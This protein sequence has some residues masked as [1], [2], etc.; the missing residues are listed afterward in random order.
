MPQAPSPL[1][2]A[3]AAALALALLLA[4]RS[5]LAA[6]P[7]YGSRVINVCA[8]EYTPLVYCTDRDPSEY[9]GFE[10][11]LFHRV[12]QQLGWDLA[13][14]RRAPASRLSPPLAPASSALS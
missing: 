1:R 8:A 12:R 5:S 2:A 6:D 11:E 13:Q 14:V 4:P 3:A 9:S 10:I 7:F